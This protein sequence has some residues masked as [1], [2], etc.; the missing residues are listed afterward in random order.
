VWPG[1]SCIGPSGG[2]EGDLI[3]DPAP[4]TNQ[5]VYQQGFSS[6]REARKEP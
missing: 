3:L 4:V 5:T 2:F 6:L 1:L